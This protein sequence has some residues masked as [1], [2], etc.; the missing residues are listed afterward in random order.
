M[1]VRSL[2]YSSLISL[3]A[4]LGPEVH[5]QSAAATP[6]VSMK[7]QSVSLAND[8]SISSEHLQAIQERIVHARFRELSQIAQAAVGRLNTEGYWKVQAEITATDVLN[9]TA[10]LRTVAVTMRIREGEQYRLKNV[11]FANKMLFQE[12]QLRQAFTINDGEVASDEKIQAGE[13][14]L[15]DLYATKGYMQPK[16]DVSTS[17][18]DEARTLSLHVAVQEGRLFTVNGL[19]LEGHQE[20][21]E[22]KAAKLQALAQLYVGSHEVG[23]FI[24]AIKKQLAEM[25]PDFDQI[26]TLVGVTM[27]G[28]ENRATVNVLY[29]EARVF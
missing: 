6:P 21:P 12:A 13:R 14:T 24:A 4:S 5:A 25:F 15:C 20:W 29:P 11:T 18:D 3:V 23:V 28:E 17:L 16:L 8:S 19:T 9:E 27:G 2:V 22:D 26:N 7:V 1:K 10:L